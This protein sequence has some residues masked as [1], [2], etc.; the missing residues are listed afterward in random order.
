MIDLSL[1]AAPVMDTY[2]WIKFLNVSG[3][4]AGFVFSFG[5]MAKSAWILK[6]EKLEESIQ[7][8]KWSYPSLFSCHAHD[9]SR[10]RIDTEVIEALSG[11]DLKRMTDAERRFVRWYRK[12]KK[13]G[14]TMWSTCGQ[15]TIADAAQDD[16]CRELMS[17]YS[18]KTLKDPDLF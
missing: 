2:D 18:A 15:V 14:I 9:S 3:M 7:D 12:Q 17:M 4:L 5:Y 8:T 11:Y 10:L 1:A 6:R 16:L 13:K